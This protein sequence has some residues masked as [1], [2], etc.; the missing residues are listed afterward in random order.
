MILMNIPEWIFFDI[1]STLVD[2][3][4]AYQNR[5]EKTIA[6]TD[7]SYDE[8]YRKMVGISKQNQDAYNSA[9]AVYGLNK[10]P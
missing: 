6:D 7:I 9:V 2:E 1:G 3:S 10:A 4:I 5:I 8:F